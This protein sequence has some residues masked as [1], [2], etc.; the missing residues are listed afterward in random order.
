MSLPT[1]PAPTSDGGTDV[2]N[3][4][5]YQSALASH[6][7]RDEQIRTIGNLAGKLLA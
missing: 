3:L 7:K 6:G 5:T 1:P 4:V 2:A